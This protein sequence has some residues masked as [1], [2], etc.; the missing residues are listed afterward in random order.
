M[1][2]TVHANRMKHFYDPADRPIAPPHE[3]DPNQLSLQAADLPADSS[4]PANSQTKTST[5]IDTAPDRDNGELPNGTPVDSSDVL[6]EPDVYAAEKILKARKQCGRHQYL[7]KWAN[8]PISESTWEPEENI[9]DKRL[10]E[11]FHSNQS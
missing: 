1:A 2:T 3:D 6:K 9:L 11:N 5:T 10:L 8:F 7:V 4:E